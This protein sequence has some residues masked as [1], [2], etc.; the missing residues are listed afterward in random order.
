M[1]TPCVAT[2]F[3]SRAIVCSAAIDIL[4][5]C[6]W[7]EQF[8]LVKKVVGLVA[9]VASWLVFIRPWMKMKIDTKVREVADQWQACA[10][11]RERA[12]MYAIKI[13]RSREGARVEASWA[14]KSVRSEKE[15][16]P[17]AFLACGVRWHTSLQYHSGQTHAR[18]TVRE[19]RHRLL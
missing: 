13:S 8:V 19:A 5:S 7:S 18:A 15:L 9:C 12:R 17:G 10:R 11:G 3:V 1:A 2:P 6:I 14:D 4:T 16:C